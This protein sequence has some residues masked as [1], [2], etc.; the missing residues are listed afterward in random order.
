MNG[1]QNARNTGGT[2]NSIAPLAGKAVETLPMKIPQVK[3]LLLAS[4]TGL[5]ALF[6]SGCNTMQ[7]AGKDI[8]KAGDKIQ[9][10][11]R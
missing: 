5:F 4:V 9:D 6:A 7:G 8:E 10:A 3:V 1:R 11:A 2:Y